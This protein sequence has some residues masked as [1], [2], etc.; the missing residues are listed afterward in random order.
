M[1]QIIA[2]G[3]I[4]GLLVAIIGIGVSIWCARD[5]LRMN[6]EL[7]QWLGARPMET[8]IDLSQ[9]SVTTVPFKQTCSVSHGEALY[10]KC[11]LDD[12]AKQNL[13]ELLKDLSGKV[14]IKDSDGNEIESVEINNKTAQYWDGKIMLT[15]FAPFRK[16]DYVATIHV[17]S[18]V[19]A[20]ADKQQTIHVEYQLCGLEQMPA[21]IAGVFAFGAGMVGLV[22]AVCVFP[23]LLRSGFW[24]D[25]LAENA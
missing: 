18:G 23:G 3:R 1:M 4:V 14:V 21:M 11:N 6:A 5:A 17:D 19:S 10:L 24:R 22:S 12:A 25:D 15:G 20:L 2:T 9:P 13:G 7:H 8:V 16:G